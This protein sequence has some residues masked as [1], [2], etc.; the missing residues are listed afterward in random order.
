MSLCRE[1]GGMTVCEMLDRMS[2]SELV[3]WTA[4]YKLEQEEIAHEE[5]K[6]KL[7]RSV[8]R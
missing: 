5:Q 4:F 3:Y 6:S 2:A 1:L 7:K 8:R